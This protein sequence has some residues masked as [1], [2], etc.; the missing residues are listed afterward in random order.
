MTTRSLES[1]DLARH[2]GWRYA[3][4]P[5]DGRDT[6]IAVGSL[7][8]AFGITVTYWQERQA[9]GANRLF[10]IFARRVARSLRV[11]IH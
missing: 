9:A 7:V 1:F 2:Y 6:R 5:S 11:K 4:I 10:S 8:L 3:P